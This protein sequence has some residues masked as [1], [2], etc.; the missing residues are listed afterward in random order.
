MEIIENNIPIEEAGRY[1]LIEIN[2]EYKTL[3]GWC[4]FYNIT[5]QS[6]YKRMKK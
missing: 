5:R 6:V 2:G 1:K 3:S 4:K